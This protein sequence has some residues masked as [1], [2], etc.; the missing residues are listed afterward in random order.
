MENQT[1]ENQSAETIETIEPVAA[2]PAAEPKFEPK[3]KKSLW[4][5]TPK[6]VVISVPLL[7]IALFA[8][9]GGYLKNVGGKASETIAKLTPSFGTAAP[10]Q[11]AGDKL[12]AARDAFAAGD[13]NAA[14]AGYRELIAA[15]PNDI[16][17]RGELGNVLYTVGAFSEASQ[18]YFEAASLAI[19]QN[20]IEVAEALFPAI[21]EGNPMLASALNDKLFDAQVRAHESE[22]MQSAQQQPMQQ[23][24][25]QG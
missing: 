18:A 25:R 13:I 1:T 15:N 21:I 3:R 4:K 16:A 7:A 8:Y 2:T 14:V 10:A 11:K 23:P 12:A 6:W 9:Q 17:A 24:Q 19:E 20:Q 5:R 22:R